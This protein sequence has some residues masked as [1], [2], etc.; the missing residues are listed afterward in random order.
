MNQ[1][2]DSSEALARID[3]DV[4]LLNHLIK[5]F[6]DDYPSL[7]ELIKLE[8]EASDAERLARAARH[9]RI[10]IGILGAQRVCETLSSLETMAANKNLKDAGAALQKLQTQLK[11]L[12]RELCEFEKAA[13]V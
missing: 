4:E 8:I 13:V 1:F 9:L 11:Q 6:L 2:F 10:S 3:G 7:L 12:D 5:L